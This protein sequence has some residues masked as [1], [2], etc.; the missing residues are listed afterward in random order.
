VLAAIVLAGHAI[1][2]GQSKPASQAKVLTVC[3]VLGDVDKYA[4]HPL[5][6]VGRME[7]S[8]SLTDHYELLAED[9]CEHPVTTE[10]HVWLNKVQIWAGWE[11]GMPKP[12]TDRPLLDRADVAIKV[13]IVRKTTQLGVH[14]EP[15]FKTEGRSLVYTHTADVPNRWAVVY[16]RI[17]RV[18]KLDEKGCGVEGCGGDDWPLVIVAEP[19]NVHVLSDEGAI[20][21]DSAPQSK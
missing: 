10:G 9:R 19:Y 2:L 3:E 4:D 21:S 20:S 18:P 5:A 13:S 6:V 16:G 11:K 1:A 14:Q 8:V 12:P 15:R 17:V 7:R